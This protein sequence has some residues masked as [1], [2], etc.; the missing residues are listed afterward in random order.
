MV[1]FVVVYI[2]IE[3]LI[4]NN[5]CMLYWLYLPLIGSMDK[6]QKNMFYRNI[7]KFVVGII[8]L[9]ISYGYIQNHP[10]ERVSIL[11]WFQVMYERGQVFV[12]EIFG[13]D[14]SVLRQKHRLEQYYQELVRIAE[15]RTCVSPEILSDVLETSIAF[16]TMPLEQLA[17]E[18]SYFSLKASELDVAIQDSCK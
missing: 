17:D 5:I 14:T 18:I 6:E 7:V 16:S 12:Y 11:S 10:A 3:M 13:K 8:L 2:S 15:S 1:L 9:S 4:E